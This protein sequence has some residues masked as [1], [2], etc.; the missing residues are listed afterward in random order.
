[1]DI[2]LNAVAI[3]NVFN[4]LVSMLS[5]GEFVALSRTCRELSKT[6]NDLVAQGLW[7]IDR[8][9]ER[10]VDEP[11]ALRQKIGESDG[12]I[13]G[14]FAMQFMD[15]ILWDPKNS[16]LDICVQSGDKAM[17][18]EKYLEEAEGY[19]LASRMV[20]KYNWVHNDAVGLHS[21]SALDDEQ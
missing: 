19:D 5:I 3:P 1:M 7:D 2:L 18:M 16:D 21:P 13:S 6:Y 11:R 4:T 10:F 9:L 12:I 15:R 8:W 20:G 14:G 17:A